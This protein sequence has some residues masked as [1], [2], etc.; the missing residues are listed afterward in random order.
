MRDTTYDHGPK[1]QSRRQAHFLAQNGTHNCTNAQDHI[2]QCGDLIDAHP[3]H[4][5]PPAAGHAQHQTKEQGYKHNNDQDARGVGQSDPTLI[6]ACFCAQKKHLIQT[7]GHGGIK[8][9]HWV[10]SSDPPIN[11]VRNTSSTG[12]EQWKQ[13]K[14]QQPCTKQPE[15]LGGD[16][17]AKHH[18]NDRHDKWAQSVGTG[19]R[20]PQHR[21]HGVCDHRAQHPGQ[22]Q[23]RKK[24][25]Y[26]TS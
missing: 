9:R 3:I 17:R 7:A 2:V 26:A 11:S 20:R 14:R 22:R 13:D 19:N 16:S 23:A 6:T 21:S 10:V 4:R 12:Q 1:D 5:S 25:G 24:G 18:T 15:N 8:C